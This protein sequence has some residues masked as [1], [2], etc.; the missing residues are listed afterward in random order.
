DMAAHDEMP[1]RPAA[2]ATRPRTPSVRAAR[3]SAAQA[4]LEF[5]LVVG[6][7]MLLV[8]ATFDVARAC[9]AYTVVASAAREAARYAAAHSTEAGWQDGAVQAGLN[10][11]VG[12]DRSA[13]SLTPSTT[14]LDGLPGVTVVSRYPFRPLAP[15]VGSVLG[16]P[17][18]LSASA[19]QVAG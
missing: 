11:A 7:F 4:S 15:V 1:L 8:A 5:A 18:W 3:R 13:L 14:A 2:A 10:L 16:N 6:L 12:I 17:I 9:L 19:W